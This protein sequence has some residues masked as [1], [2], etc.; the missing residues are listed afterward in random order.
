MYKRDETNGSAGELA[1]DGFAVFCVLLRLLA[2]RYVIMI[3]KSYAEFR[4]GVSGR[5]ARTEDS[6][7]RLMR[8]LCKHLRLAFHRS[9]LPASTFRIVEFGS[10]KTLCPNTF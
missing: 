4:F 1:R 3:A 2:A 9:I 7:S 5:A 6:S 10:P 8:Q